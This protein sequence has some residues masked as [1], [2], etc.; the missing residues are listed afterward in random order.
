MRLWGAR[1]KGLEG[2]AD[3][4][5]DFLDSHY[6]LLHERH[7]PRGGLNINYFTNICSGSYLRPMDFE[8]S[9]F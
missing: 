8:I 1:C 2:M 3:L 9:L 4:V 7:L 6:Q 5:L